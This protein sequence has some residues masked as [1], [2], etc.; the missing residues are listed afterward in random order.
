LPDAIQVCC[1]SSP[2]SFAVA[3]FVHRR[4][5]RDATQRPFTRWKRRFIKLRSH[6]TLHGTPDV[7]RTRRGLR[8][9]QLR[10]SRRKKHRGEKRLHYITC[11]TFTEL[12]QQ[13]KRRRKRVWKLCGQ[14][15]TPRVIRCNVIAL[16]AL[17]ET[18]GRFSVAEPVY[19]F[20]T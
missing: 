8:Y 16:C 11:E 20:R 10:R 15:H 19:T 2:I 13:N 1:S 14:L 9:N 7:D 5:R 4:H 6:G 12:T 3:P 18:R 17:F